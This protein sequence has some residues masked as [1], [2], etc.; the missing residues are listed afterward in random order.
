MGNVLVRRLIL[1]ALF[2]EIGLLLI[3]LPWSAFWAR[4]Y[5]VEALPAIGPVL[6]NHFV[7]GAVSGLGIVNLFAGI[8]ELAPVFVIRSGAGAPVGDRADT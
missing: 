8:A 4:N 3:V 5:F 2:V 7:R 1:A 6:T